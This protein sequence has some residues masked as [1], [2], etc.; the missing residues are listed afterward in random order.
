MVRLVA[1]L[2]GGGGGGGRRHHFGTDQQRFHC[3]VI[4]FIVN[5][6]PQKVDP[7]AL[8]KLL[9]EFKDL[10]LVSIPRLPLDK[11]VQVLIPLIEGA[12]IVKQPMFRYSPTEW[13]EIE[14]QVDYLLKRGL[15]IEISSPFGAQVLF[16]PKPNGTLQ[17]CID[18][19]GLNKLTRN[20]C[21][22]MPWVNNLLDLLWGARLFL[23]IYLMQGYYQIRIKPKDYKKTALR[24][25]GGLYEFKVLPFSLANAPIVFQTLMNK[26]FDQQI[27]KNVLV[28][29]D[30]MPVYNK[31]PEDHIRHLR[32]VF[33]I[34]RTQK[35]FCRLHK[36]HFNDM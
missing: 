12:K 10:F 4:G 16:V 31:T 5:G 2:P 7:E 25:L 17:M 9:Q 21:Y 27:G 24:T 33:K 26:T 28:Y 30:D 32:E 6:T 36:C 3:S 8:K 19:R 29:L 15:I 34:L 11:G 22:T 35:F 13:E 14:A 20:T 18:Y 1:D 23:T